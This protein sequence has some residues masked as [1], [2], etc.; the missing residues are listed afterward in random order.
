MNTPGE[1]RAHAR[2]LHDTAADYRR[3][4]ASDD[5]MPHWR[6]KWLSDA[7]RMD[8]DADW[9]E[10]SACCGEIE[11]EYEEITKFREAAE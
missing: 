8:E 6:K 11:V 4:A 10:A 2:F 9:Y 3:M 1:R 7:D 5:V